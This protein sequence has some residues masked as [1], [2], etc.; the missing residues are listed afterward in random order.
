MQHKFISNTNTRSLQKSMGY[1]IKHRL[2]TKQTHNWS[3]HFLLEE[4]T[5]ELTK[6][7]VQV[8]KGFLKLGARHNEI[9]YTQELNTTLTCTGL[10]DPLC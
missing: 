5:A 3:C 2:L 10:K 7:C 8:A 9:L 6:S 4:E 1:T